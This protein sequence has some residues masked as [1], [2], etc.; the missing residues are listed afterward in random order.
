MDVVEDID[1]NDFLQLEQEDIYGLDQERYAMIL[2]S[3]RK[4]CCRKS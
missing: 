1:P 3:N 4:G 2:L